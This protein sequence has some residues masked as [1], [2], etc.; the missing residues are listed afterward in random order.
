MLFRDYPKAVSER[1]HLPLNMKE[2]FFTGRDIKHVDAV[3][4]VLS[5]IQY[6]QLFATY[7]IR[8]IDVLLD[9]YEYVTVATDNLNHLAVIIWQSNVV[10]SKGL[11]GAA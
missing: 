9:L 10:S 5:I 2:N 6:L 7:L 4:L 1:S 11:P 8:R 3:F